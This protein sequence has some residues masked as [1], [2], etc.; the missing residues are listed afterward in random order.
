M[1]IPGFYGKFIAKQ[2]RQAILK[3]KPELVS[4]VSFD[5]NGIFHA[6]RAYVLGDGETDNPELARALANTDPLQIELEMQNAISS[7]ILL[8][9][10]SLNPQDCII[11]AVD[12]PAPLAKRVQQRQRREKASKARAPNEIFDSNAITPGTEFMIRLDNFMVRFISTYKKS[13][14]AK[15]VYSSHLVP[16]EGEHKIMDY[17][18]SDFM[19]RDTEGVHIL[20]GLDADLIM[21]SLLSGLDGIYLSRENLNEFVSI[22]I[23]KEY[24]TSQSN[25]PSVI[26]DFVVMMY[27]VGNDFLP[28]NPALSDME[29]TIPL[30][31]DIYNK[32][33]YVLTYIDNNNQHQ[34]NWDSF[35]LFMQDLAESESELLAS[36]STQ[37]YE[38]PSPIFQTAIVKNQFYIDRFRS[39]WYRNA[40]GP[41]G[42]TNFTESL[43]DILNIA[44]NQ[45]P[46]TIGAITTE[47][48]SKMCFDYMKVMAWTYLYYREGTKAV[49][50]ELAYEYYHSPLIVDLS[51]VMQSINA[52]HFITGIEYN[53]DQIQ[54]TALH[55]LVA[56]LPLKSRDLLPIELKPLFSYNSSLRDM[57]PDDFIVEMYG[58]TKA[59]EGIAIIPFIDSQRVIDAVAQVQ[60]SVERAKLWQPAKD[61]IP[62]RTEIERGFIQHTLLMTQRHQ[63]FLNRKAEID[64]SRERHK[65]TERRQYRGTTQSSRG[66]Y[67]SSRGGYRSQ[68]G[69]YQSSRGGYQSSRGGYRSQ[70]GGYR[71]QEGGYQ[72]SRGGYQSSRGGYRSQEGGFQSS[73]GGYQSSR[74]GSRSQEGGFQSSRGRF[75][76]QGDRRPK[77]EQR[78]TKDWSTTGSNQAQALDAG[79]QPFVPQGFYVP[80]TITQPIATTTSSQGVNTGLG[81]SL[82]PMGMSLQSGLIVGKKATVTPSSTSSPITPIDTLNLQTSLQPSV[83][84][85]NS[86][87]PILPQPQI[88]TQSQQPITNQSRQQSQQQYQQQSNTNQYQQ[89]SQQQYQQQ[90]N[91][92]Q[93]QQ[94]PNTNQYQQQR[95]TNQYQQQRN[96]SQSRQQ[97]NTNQ[98]QPNTN[99]Y[100]EEPNTSQSREQSQ[101]PISTQTSRRQGEPIQRRPTAAIQPRTVS[102]QYQQSKQQGRQQ[103]SQQPRSPSQQS[104]LLM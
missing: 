9:I 2:I 72:S 100:R 67:Q 66:G 91:T 5:L 39:A 88:T 78:E 83:T 73:R 32:G 57:F 82:L 98:Y 74:G 30:L 46:F 87:L 104:Q 76:S 95:N 25:K 92:N 28:H 86:Q 26:D 68:E 18:R 6:A 3:R 1:G 42:P 11:F 59:R 41:R 4:S 103:G 77:F 15:I 35:K 19:N 81:P 29:Q 94:Q 51:A 44:N 40:L 45:T 65:E 63:E 58:K 12:G 50:Q 8:V 96:I 93:Y 17:Y 97:S 49:N 16:G 61:W 37:N 69:G 24:F 71:S 80:S 34:I 23:I 90:P 84:S 53:P 21:L 101:Q 55:Q 27:L 64:A 20:Y 47:G 43:I 56:V 22:D 54:F 33:D 99:Q 70:D 85:Q 52:T 62:P 31:L 79:S 60:F 36:I 89:Q 13:F 38:N 14:P 102:T 48:I 7:L 75:Q 10:Q